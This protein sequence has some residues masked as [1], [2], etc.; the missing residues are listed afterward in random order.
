MS[1]RLGSRISLQVICV[2]QLIDLAPCRPK[3]PPASIDCPSAH[4]EE[5]G[6]VGD[7]S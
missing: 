4:I 5:D 1:K 7:R 2:L 3:A 6:Y